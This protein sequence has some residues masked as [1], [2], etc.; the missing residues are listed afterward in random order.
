MAFHR[1]E[2]EECHQLGSSPSNF[3]CRFLRVMGIYQPFVVGQARK[4]TPQVSLALYYVDIGYN[5][6]SNTSL[7]FLFLSSYT[8]G[9]KVVFLPNVLFLGLK[10]CLSTHCWNCLCIV[11]QGHL[12][13]QDRIWVGWACCGE[14]LAGFLSVAEK[15]EKSVKGMRWILLTVLWDAWE[16]LVATQVVGSRLHCEKMLRR[17]GRQ[18]NNALLSWPFC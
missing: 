15:R 6:I 7:H 9:V 16:I 13:A 1:R 14:M 12:W 8:P 5:R 2:G 10:A 3:E 4:W 11:F 17:D 18:W